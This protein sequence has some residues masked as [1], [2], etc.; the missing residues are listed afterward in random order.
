LSS[1]DKIHCDGLQEECD[2]YEC[3]FDGTDCTY[4]TLLYPNCSAIPFD[5]PCYDLFNNGVCDR[6][7]NSAECLFD[8]WDCEDE[9]RRFQPCN[10]VYDRYCLEHYAD[11]FCDQGCNVAECV[12]DGL[13]CVNAPRR[14]ESGLLVVFLTVPPAR[15][16]EVRTEFLR[17]LGALLHT[18]VA[19]ARDSD[20][21]EMIVP[22][23]MT[24]GARRERRSVVARVVDNLFRQKRR[25]AN[26]G[27]ATTTTTTTTT[28]TT[29]TTTNTTIIT[30]TTTTT[31]TTT[32]NTTT[33]ALATTTTT[34]TTARSSHTP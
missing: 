29:T 23:Q 24:D 2:T 27:Y 13:D 16:A 25:A 20:G 18:V 12:W 22:W 3:R 7:C 19:V 21:N 28:I 26:V 10:P 32:T 17:Q 14:Y 4:T 33:T 31:A 5:I 9:E 34:T 30:M 8:G 11:G 1:N 6:A 15:F